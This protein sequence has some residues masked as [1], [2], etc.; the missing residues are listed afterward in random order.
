M[1]NNRMYLTN[2]RTGDKVCLAKYY[3]STGWY[4]LDDNGTSK[5]L[6]QRMNEAMTAAE[7]ETTAW[8]DNDWVV[9]YE[10]A[11]DGS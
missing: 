8:G 1:A 7:P 3:P 6:V 5:N 10:H 4:A 9:E 2:K 11:P